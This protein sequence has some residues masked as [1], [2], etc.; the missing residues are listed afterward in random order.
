[1][2]AHLS[3]TKSISFLLVALLSIVILT[4]TSQALDLVQ[5][6]HLNTVR[7]SALFAEADIFAPNT[8]K[9]AEKEYVKAKRSINAGKRQKD[10]DKAVSRAREYVDNAIKATEVTKLTLQEYLE[11]RNKARTAK[12]SLLVPK[13]YDKAEKQFVKATAK[14]ES[15]NVK[16]ALKDAAKSTS[17]FSVA[18]MEAIRV[19]I[20]GKADRLI[21]KA[22]ADDGTKYAVSTIDKAMT[23]RLKANSILTNDRYNRIEAVEEA[24]RAEYEAR[25]ASNIARSV[26]SLNRNDQAWEKLILLYEIQ[27]SRV[28]NAMEIEFLPYDN[29]PLAAADDMISKINALKKANAN[30]ARDSEY[31]SSAVVEKLR[32]ILAT[33]GESAEENDPIA[34]GTTVETALANLMQENAAQA[35]ELE[36]TRQ[37]LSNLEAIHAEIEADLNARVEQEER[38]IRAKTMLNPS[39]GEVLFN[40]SNDVVLRLSGISFDVNK[41]TIK[42]EHMPLLAKVKEII[43]MFPNAFLMIEGHTDASGNAAANVLLSEKRA[44]AIMQYIRQSLLLSADKIQSMGYGMDRPVASNQTNEGRSKNRRIDIIIMR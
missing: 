18:E 41:S 39:E 32:D 15:G 2:N 36:A 25:H 11:P 37:K 9:K 12:A 35:D 16:S 22:A 33:I 14:V 3:L 17:L 6:G 26:R 19:D 29:G 5:Y 4:S 31:L 7:D 34:M 42:D 20:L 43:K 40:S 24:K 21:E 13:I 1:M 44:Y 10:I 28:G 27:M 8:W 30:L 23:A 38:F